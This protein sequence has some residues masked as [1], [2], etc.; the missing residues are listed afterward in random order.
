MKT[1][2]AVFVALF[3]IDTLTVISAAV[4]ARIELDKERAS[5]LKNLNHSIKN[6]AFK[7]AKNV[8]K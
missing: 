8:R 4:Q 6:P 5:V 1:F 2:I 3:V 7:G